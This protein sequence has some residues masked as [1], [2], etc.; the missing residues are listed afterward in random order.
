MSYLE[1]SLGIIFG[2]YPLWSALPVALVSLRCFSCT[3]RLEMILLDVYSS[4]C[5]LVIKNNAVG[6]VDFVQCGIL[7]KSCFQFPEALYNL[8]SLCV[9]HRRMRN[10][11]LKFLHN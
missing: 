10:F 9:L 7:E 2:D 6:K 8:C 3:E 1:M 4:I 11:C 5:L